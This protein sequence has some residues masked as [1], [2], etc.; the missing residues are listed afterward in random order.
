MWWPMAEVKAGGEEVSVD[1]VL[2]I[3]WT[4]FRYGKGHYQ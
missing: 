2:Q 1:V 3:L 4:T